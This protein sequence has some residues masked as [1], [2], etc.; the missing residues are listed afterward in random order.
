[1]LGNSLERVSLASDVGAT[2]RKWIAVVCYLAKQ[3]P[4]SLAGRFQTEHAI[5][6]HA[7]AAAFGPILNDE[8]LMAGGRY[9][10]PE[11]RSLGVPEDCPVRALVSSRP[12]HLGRRQSSPHGRSSLETSRKP[13]VSAG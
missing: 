12:A 3:G 8:A 10:Q 2:L 4:C 5:D 7:P 1:A 13:R 6:C 11:A 9:L